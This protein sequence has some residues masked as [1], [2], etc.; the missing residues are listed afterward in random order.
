MS[1]PVLRPCKHCGTPWWV[2]TGAWGAVQGSAECPDCAQFLWRVVHK[3]GANPRDAV[4]I[5]RSHLTAMAE[6]AALKEATA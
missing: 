3:G 6:M 5:L 2:L 1:A 4:S